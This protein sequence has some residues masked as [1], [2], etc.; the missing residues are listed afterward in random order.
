MD[1]TELCFTPATELAAAI[2]RRQLS[3]VEIIDAVLARIEAVNPRLN[4]YLAV[5]AERARA[6]ARVAEAGVMRGEIKGA[7]YGLPVSIK[8]LEPSA[9][10]RCT[11]GSKFFEHAVAEHDGAVT[12]RV[13][14][15]GGIVIGKTNTSHYGHKD[16]CDNL[17][18]PPCR[19]PWQLD[20]TSG[21]SS[22]GA[23]SRRSCRARATGAW[24]RWRRVDSHSR[25]IVWCL[26]SQTV[27]WTG[28]KLA[29]CGHL[30]GAFA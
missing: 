27:V 9:G 2:R 13:K 30:G 24:V 23:G 14:A 8:D 12:T 15:A 4:A 21:A 25:G 26:W 10:M 20:R 28:A 3:P 16:M 1:V 22:G 18:G 19:N 5:D 17:I 29:Q 6:A 11:Y 7:L